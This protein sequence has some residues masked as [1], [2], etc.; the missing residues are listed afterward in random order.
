MIS[1]RTRTVVI[2]VVTAVWAANFIAGVAVKGYQ[3]SE[4]IN[5]IFMAIVGG[6]F[7]LGAKGGTHSS[8]GDSA[9]PPQS[10]PPQPVQTTPESTSPLPP[11]APE[12]GG[13]GPST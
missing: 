8:N 2:A 3:P 1:A 7:A 11:P 12:H 13:G 4:S 10:P 5:G 6:L 9:P